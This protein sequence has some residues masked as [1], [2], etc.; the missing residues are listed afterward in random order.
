MSSERGSVGGHLPKPPEPLDAAIEEI[1]ANGEVTVLP[2]DAGPT[3][4]SRVLE[5]SL[6]EDATLRGAWERHALVSRAA[7]RQQRR[8]RRQQATILGLG[9][10]V[11][12]LVVVQ[13][14]LG[15]PT[16][17]DDKALL[18]DAL[19]VAII[20]IP[21]IVTTLLAA[22]ARLRPGARWILL[23]GTAEGLKRENLSVPGP[24]GPIQPG[25][26]ARHG[27]VGQAGHGR[28]FGNGRV[29]AHRGEPVGP[30]GAG[31]LG[32]TQRLAGLPAPPSG[33]GRNRG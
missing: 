30:G 26:D 13:A 31:S 7:S 11:T 9:V 6:G 27:R 24:C 12:L 22:A 28:R 8:Y 15:E 19:R 33:P 29:D 14:S 25:T 10:L 21:I 1:V 5:R 3:T 17:P 2:L 18:R 20:L 16:V 23:R 4:L 32:S